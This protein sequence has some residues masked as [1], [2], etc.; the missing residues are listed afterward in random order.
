M[1]LCTV[2]SALIIIRRPFEFIKGCISSDTIDYLLR[3]QC[4]VHLSDEDTDK[5]N[6]PQLIWPVFNWGIIR[7]KDIRNHSSSG[8]IWKNFPLE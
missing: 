6:D 2:S 8:F 1:Q 3:N 4:E 5:V 7:C